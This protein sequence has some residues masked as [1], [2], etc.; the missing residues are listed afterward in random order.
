MK[1]LSI[2]S[3]CVRNLRNL[4]QVDIE[5]CAGIN[6][7]VG[8]NGQGK[9]SLLEAAYAVATTRSFR[10]LRSR[11]LISHGADA[12]S[13]RAEVIKA[14]VPGELLFS[15]SQTRR[16]LKVDQE[17]TPS[18]MEYVLCLPVVVF[19]AGELEL[20]AGRAHARRRLLD[21]VALFV[22]WRSHEHKMAHQRAMKARQKLLRTESASVA[23]IEAY[24]ELMATHGVALAQHRREVSGELIETA[25]KVVVELGGGNIELRA[26]FVSTDL[27]SKGEV[28]EKL[29]A[30]R[31][32]DTR[33]NY[34]STGP[35][36]DDLVLEIGGRPARLVASQGQ[37]RLITLGLKVAE[38]TCIAASVG[39]DPVLL[40]DDVSSEL[41]A[42]RTKALFGLLGSRGNQV[43][44]TTARPEMVLDLSAA[45]AE[46]RVYRMVQGRAELAEKSPGA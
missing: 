21:R 15:I 16:L 1:Q 28:V 3:L 23:A 11:E 24:E 9:T 36:R 32:V 40:L 31:R 19:H 22:D 44:V 14:G 42:E 13:V 20:S 6:V 7:V 12:C 35:H 45:V 46:T 37:H 18:L 4:L 30:C 34:A 39:F 27:E 38:M 5:P 33:R 29:R 10:T 2:R 25:Q 41:D 8:D 17:K 26:Q 43:F